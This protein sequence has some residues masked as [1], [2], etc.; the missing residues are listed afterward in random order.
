MPCSL[1]VHNLISGLAS[2]GYRRLGCIQKKN[3]IK[4]ETVFLTGQRNQEV[5]KMVLPL[6]CPVCYAY[7]NEGDGNDCY[8]CGHEFYPMSCDG[9]CSVCN[10][11]GGQS[12]TDLIREQNMNEF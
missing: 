10:P 4:L 7:V 3:G 12:Q 9:D 8:L 5:T 6:K 1:K 2:K 11:K